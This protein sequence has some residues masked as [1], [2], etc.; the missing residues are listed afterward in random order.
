MLKKIS[1]IHKV[2]LYINAIFI[3]NCEIEITK[4]ENE[5]RCRE[6]LLTG[7][8][9]S[10]NSENPASKKEE[11]KESNLI[12]YGACLTGRRPFGGTIQD[13]IKESKPF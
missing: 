9:S 6:Y 12:F 13:T 10:E 7:L 5:K 1:K 3:L 2:F 11:L 8:L 4:K